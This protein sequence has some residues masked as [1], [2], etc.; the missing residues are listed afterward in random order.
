MEKRPFGKTGHHSSVAIFGSACLDKHSQETANQTIEQALSAG[1]NTF[2]TA[3]AY[4]EAELR[5]GAWIN[6]FHQQ[7]GEH[8]PLPFF[9]A[10]KNG[11]RRRGKAHKEL[12]K[13]LHRLQ[14]EQI[15]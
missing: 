14:V 7:N 4:G 11:H 9:L 12:E 3:P 8:A 2:D 6:Q 10:T 15:D 13:S 1:V 5:L